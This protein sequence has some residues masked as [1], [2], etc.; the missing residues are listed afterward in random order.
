MTE[1]SNPASHPRFAVIRVRGPAW[2][3]ARSMR[4]QAGWPEHAQFMNELAASGFI[5][6][7]G[8]LGDGR[9]VLLICHAPDEEAI[10]LRISA[11]PWTKDGLLEVASIDPWH[12]L[13]GALPAPR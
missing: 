7:G 10:R 5:A 1:T 12:I 2:D 9:R 6:F 11:D 4:E 13:L 3:H 8:P